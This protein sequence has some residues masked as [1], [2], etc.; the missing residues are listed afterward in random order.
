MEQVNLVISRHVGNLVIHMI[1]RGQYS[2]C[3]RPAHKFDSMVSQLGYF[4]RCTGSRTVQNG[5]CK[6]RYVTD[7]VIGRK[8]AIGKT[9]K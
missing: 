8:I 2:K 9:S 1:R 5:G 3:M 4:M 7:A 6:H